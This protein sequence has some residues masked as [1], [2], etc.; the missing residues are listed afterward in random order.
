VALSSGTELGSYEILS[1]IGA[2][3][4]GEVYRA[5]DRKLKREVAI[6]VLPAPFAADPDRVFRFQR[7][8]EAL[9]ALNHSNIAGIYDLQETAGTRFLVL[10]LVDGENLADRLKRG[11]IPLDEALSIAR[12]ISDGL[13]AAHEKGII[14]R[15]LKPANITMTANGHVKL[16]DFGL[17]RLFESE[18]QNDADSSHSPT[19]VTRTGAGVILGTAAYMSPEQARGRTTGKQADIWAFGVV[20]YEML[21]GERL[22]K[23]E[24]TSEILAAVIKEEPNLDRVPAKVRR[25]LRR[26]LEKDPKR[27]LRDI[28]DAW[29]LL[30]E[31]P[32]VPPSVQSRSWLPWGAAALFFL[33]ALAAAPLAFVHFREKPPALDPVR[34]DVSIPENVILGAG[35]FALSP[36]GRQL[37]FAPAGSDG[38]TRLWV[39]SLDS[40]QARPIP[41]TEGAGNYP[42]FWSP[43]SRFIGFSVGNKYMKVPVSGGPPQTL[44]ELPGTLGASAWNR[45]GVILVGANPGGLWRVPETGGVPS[46]VTSVDPSRQEQFHAKPWFLPDGRH[47]LY[48]RAAGNPEFTGTYIG[49]LDLEPKQQDPKRILPGSPAAQYVRSPDP[50]MGYV[51]FLREGTLMAQAFDNRRL[52]LTGEA[53]PIAEQV[54]TN[55]AVSGFFAASDN[56]VLAFRTGGGGN[57]QF[58]WVDN[59]GKQIGIVG[60]PGAYFDVALSPDATRLAVYRGSTHHRISGYTS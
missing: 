35:G 5:R 59:Q 45:D 60:D 26:C 2:G 3:G 14:H 19:L 58:K 20:L 34:F 8:A 52:E 38:T 32:S 33:L 41:G 39:R 47:F 9:A 55:A 1:A 42:P 6:K 28:A 7:E 22:F 13:E 51:L 30:D 31:A 36:D 43:D 46:P 12:Q 15:D 57:R 44:C 4:M 11:A 37:V 48:Y 49:S 17:A 27:R 40:L 50:A 10:E 53:V 21:T 16:L 23:G 54:G 56:G 29:A 24:D 18:A 25:L